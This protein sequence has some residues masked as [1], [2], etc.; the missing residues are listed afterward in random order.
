MF[1]TINDGSKMALAAL[2]QVCEHQGIVAI[3][4]QQNTA[5]LASM[6][7]QEMSRA[8]FLALTHKAKQAPSPNWQEATVDWDHWRS[9]KT[10]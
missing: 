4:C 1:S 2:V 3:D 9:G 5:H 10:A 6:G 7:A 8:E